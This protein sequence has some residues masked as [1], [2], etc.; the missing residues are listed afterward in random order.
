MRDAAGQVANRLQLL[1]LLQTRLQ[2]GALDRGFLLGRDVA[3]GAHGAHRPALRALAFKDGPRA[4][5]D[6]GLGSVA[7]V[8]AMLQI[9][10]PALASLMHGVDRDAHPLDI[11]RMNGVEKCRQENGLVGGHPPDGALLRRPVA[12][13]GHEI[14]IEDADVRRAQHLRQPL[15]ALAQRLLDVLAAGDV[16]HDRLHRRHAAV[17]VAQRLQYG[18]EPRLDAAD[19]RSILALQRDAAVDDLLDARTIPGGDV[20]RKQLL[21]RL[22]GHRLR[23]HAQIG[24]GRDVDVEIPAVRI[25]DEDWIVGRLDDRAV[26]IL[27]HVCPTAGW[28]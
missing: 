6:P 3:R 12:S 2:F 16:A 25:R 10:Q 11:V 5:V 14:V 21:H 23:R 20:R 17:G 24:G 7:P 4:D 27:D 18:A 28:R 15:F 13:M 1:R 19:F 9:D 22:A 8:D 26:G